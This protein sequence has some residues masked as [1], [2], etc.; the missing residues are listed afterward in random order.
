MFGPEVWLSV[1]L[2]KLH[3]SGP[4][5]S[6]PNRKMFARW[7]PKGLVAPISWELGKGSNRDTAP[8]TGGVGDKCGVCS[9]GIETNMEDVGC[10]E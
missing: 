5:S 1:T 8:G 10:L 2:S 7:I 6:C 4:Q 3:L 9:V